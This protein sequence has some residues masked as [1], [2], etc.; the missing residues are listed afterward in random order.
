VRTVLR[1]LVLPTATCTVH[2]P[3][4]GIFQRSVGFHTVRTVLRYLVLP[5]ATCTVHVPDSTVALPGTTDCCLMLI[6]IPASTTKT[7][8]TYKSFM[9]L[10]RMFINMI[11]LINMGSIA[12]TQ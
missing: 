11:T 2:V 1:Y 3:K 4:F 8:T 5:T 7:L 10:L 9:I 12:I 6:G